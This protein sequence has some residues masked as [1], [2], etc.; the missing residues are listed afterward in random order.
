MDIALPKEGAPL[1]MHLVGIVAALRQQAQ[2][3]IGS[4]RDYVKW[5]KMLGVSPNKLRYFILNPGSTPEP[6]L[7]AGLLRYFMPHI[8]VMAEE[9]SL[10]PIPVFPPEGWQV[11]PN[12]HAY[13]WNTTTR[14]VLLEADLRRRAVARST[15][16]A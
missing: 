14:E 10:P 15:V 1:G 16:A 13:Y 4:E 5:G 8:K 9:P 3:V 11:H 7:M 12:N 2:S 6:E